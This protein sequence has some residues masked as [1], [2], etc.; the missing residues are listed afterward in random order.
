[1]SVQNTRDLFEHELQDIY[2]AEHELTSAYERMAEHTADDE[3]QAFFEEHVDETA[4]HIERLVEVFEQTDEPPQTEECE[5]IE[6]LLT[7]WEGFL[8]EA[9]SGPLLDYYNLVTAVKTERYEQ[10]AY[11]SLVGLAEH[12]GR[13]EAADLLR[14]NLAEDEAT[15]DELG[16]MVDD[17]DALS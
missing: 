14:E 16:E 10:S 2:F 17:Y 7:E 9:E 12:E 11:E 3:I 6:G 13:S 1:M 15:L 4:D 8:D 5:G